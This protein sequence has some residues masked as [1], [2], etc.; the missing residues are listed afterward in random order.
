MKIDLY[1]V[2]KAMIIILYLYYY[3]AVIDIT[4]IMYI[5]LSSPKYLLWESPIFSD[6]VF[7]LISDM[8]IDVFESF[9]I[10]R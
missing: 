6:I 7:A 3:S 9:L 8:K 1:F 10:D 4:L 2:F 5:T